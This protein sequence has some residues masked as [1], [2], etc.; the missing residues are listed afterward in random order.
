MSDE[1]IAALNELSPEEL[2]SMADDFYDANQAAEYIS[3]NIFNSYI[4]GYA[5]GMKR[6]RSAI[7]GWNGKDT[8]D[9]TQNASFELGSWIQE[10][11]AQGKS[12]KE[13]IDEYKD[14]KG[15][16]FKEVFKI[17]SGDKEAKKTIKDTMKWLSNA[18]VEMSD[19]TDEEIIGLIANGAI[20]QGNSILQFVG[21]A[22]QSGDNLFSMVTDTFGTGFKS[23]LETV[24]AEIQNPEYS[25]SISNSMG[26]SIQNGIVKGTKLSEEN[27]KKCSANIKKALK[28]VSDNATAD[29]K[30]AFKDN[31]QKLGEKKASGIKNGLTTSEG[32][33]ITTLK[34]VAKKVTN[35]TKSTYKNYGNQLGTNM[36]DG[37]AIGIRNG[38]SRAISAAVSVA[39]AAYQAAKAAID[40]NSPSKKFMQL[41][42]WSSE[43]FAIGIQNGTD[44]VT[45]SITDMA[46]STLTGM[47]EAI[48]TI[49]DVINGDLE[50]SPVI[51][52][53]LDLSLLN[54]QVQSTGQLFDAKVRFAQEQTE[55]NATN[56][57]GGVNQTFVQNNYSPKAL[58]REEIY[59]QT[60]NQFAMARKVVNGNAQINYGY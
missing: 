25:E 50:L 6:F 15:D 44:N 47:K 38:E 46:K 20:T 19:K 4:N 40:S 17:S 8:G 14:L 57:N 29:S 18:L 13:I 52:P 55:Q 26:T 23:V 30:A 45:S 60:K 27:V 11:R 21:E 49:N 2:K 36:V 56:Q 10:Q 33:I 43:G 5:E 28:K 32:T 41:G 24:G 54:R 35:S 59:R 1:Q 37:L 58:S 7:S 3:D 39:V 42:E 31:G 9:P 22:M 16:A 12:L 34:S 48:S 51:T 53:Q